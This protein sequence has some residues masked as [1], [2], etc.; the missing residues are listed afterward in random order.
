MDGFISF[1]CKSIIAI[2]KSADQNISISPT[3]M[4]WKYLM[5]NQIIGWH[6]YKYKACTLMFKNMRR[7]YM[8]CVEQQV[9]IGHK[10][11]L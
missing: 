7:D 10:W 9:L 11:I 5:S 6:Y 4:N 8:A 2:L 1:L 3:F